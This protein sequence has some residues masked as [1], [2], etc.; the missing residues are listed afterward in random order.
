MKI[1]K[2][3]AVILSITLTA[4]ICAFSVT[5]AAASDEEF[6][7]TQNP[8]GYC[9][10]DDYSEICCLSNYCLEPEGGRLPTGDY[11]TLDFNAPEDLEIISFQFRVLCSDIYIT[12][13]DYSCF[14]SKMAYNDRVKDDRLLIGNVSTLDPI[15]VK[16][17]ETLVSL[18]ISSYYAT[19]A[20]IYVIVDDLEIHTEYGD[21]IIVQDGEILE[22]EVI[23]DVNGNNVVD[24]GDATTLQKHI[25]EFTVDGESIIDETDDDVMYIADVDR[26]HSITI[27]DVTLIQQY[28]AEYIKSFE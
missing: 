27:K 8:T 9:T 4:G 15:S 24:I 2:L 10:V 17:G 16:K 23:G 26:D 1:K 11:M 7:P 3:L 21:K 5:S 13:E 19:Y 28:L 22:R 12:L 14:T 25:A 20:D 6:D 18:T